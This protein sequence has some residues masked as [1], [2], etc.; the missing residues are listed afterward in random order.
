MG[1][2]YLVISFHLLGGGLPPPFPPPWPR[3]RPNQL[4][5]AIPGDH[6]SQI[7]RDLGP[8]FFDPE[9][10][11]KTIPA[12]ASENQKKIDPRAPQGPI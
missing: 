7:F 11:R 1:N 8:T 10:H 4:D 2:E 5:S 12:K 6:F 9:I 3:L